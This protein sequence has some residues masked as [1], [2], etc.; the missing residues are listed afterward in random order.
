MAN[1]VAR[2][3]FDPMASSVSS[4]CHFGHCSLYSY[5]K[6]DGFDSTFPGQYLRNECEYGNHTC[7]LQTVSNAIIICICIAGYIYIYINIYI[8]IYIYTLNHTTMSITF[9]YSIVKF[10]GI[11]SLELYTQPHY[12]EHYFPLQYCQIYWDSFSWIILAIPAQTE[13]TQSTCYSQQ[14]A[15]PNIMLLDF[16]LTGSTWDN[17]TCN[18]CENR[19]KQLCW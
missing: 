16:S 15:L 12:N 2:N 14:R 6:E 1:Y 3:H 18:L 17:N 8:Y 13:H 11:L 9:R 10:I 7:T 19:S 4:K 5:L